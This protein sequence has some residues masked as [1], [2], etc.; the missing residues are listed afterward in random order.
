MIRSQD[1]AWS[2]CLILSQTEVEAG[3]E[4]EIKIYAMTN[5]LLKWQTLSK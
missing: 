5:N 4:K 1:H 2:I 3:L